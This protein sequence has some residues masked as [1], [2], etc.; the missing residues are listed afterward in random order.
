[1]NKIAVCAIGLS[2]ALLLGTPP[3]TVRGHDGQDHQE[4]RNEYGTRED[5]RG[6]EPQYEDDW[7]EGEEYHDDTYRSSS[8]R[9]P[10]LE[11]WERSAPRERRE[12]PW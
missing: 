1:M 5:A 7:H 4:Q 10:P 6:Y 9:Y 3:T 2:A 12:R 11:D 8:R